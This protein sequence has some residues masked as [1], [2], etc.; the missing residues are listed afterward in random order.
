MLLFADYLNAIKTYR[1]KVRLGGCW[2]GCYEVACFIEYQFG[3][4]RVDGVYALPDGRP[5]F[6]HSWNITP[7]GSLCDGTADQF[8]EGYDVVRL[9]AGCVPAERYR[10]RYTTVHNP[11]VT[12]WLKGAPYVGLSDRSFWDNAE[13]EK[14]LPPGW[15]L[16]DRVTYLSWFANGVRQYPMFASMRDRYRQR[17]YDVD[18]LG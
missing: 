14:A 12:P 9:D 6:L 13:E 4:R 3:W 7:D 17:G 10:E 2:G 18:D 16:A 5:I 1:H 8:G 11:S 15:W